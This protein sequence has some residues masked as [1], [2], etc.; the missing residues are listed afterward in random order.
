MF[1]LDGAFPSKV[2][3]GHVLAVMLTVSDDTATRLC[4]LVVPAAEVNQILVAKGF[5]KTQVKPVADPNRFFL[6]KTTPRETHDLLQKLVQGKLLSPASTE[7]LLGVLRSPIAFTDGIRRSM[8]SAERLRIATKAGFFTDGRHEAGII[9]DPAGKPILTYALFA[10]G[11]A[12]TDDFGATHPAVEARAVMG[13]KF[14][15]AV[16]QL[17]SPHR[18]ARSARRPTART[19]AAR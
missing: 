11:Q 5:P 7:Y 15:D 16:D 8:S 2:T 10:R 17:T 12:G 1:R 3:L 9:F 14:L 13:R 18:S 6:G 4:G 19:T